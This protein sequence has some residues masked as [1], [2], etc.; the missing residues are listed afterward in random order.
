MVSVPLSTLTQFSGFGLGFGEPSF[1]LVQGFDDYFRCYPIAM[2]SDLTRKDDANYGGKIFLPQSALHKLTML[3]IR[4]PMLFHISSEGSGKSTHSGVLEFTAEEGRCYLP[5]WMLDTI[6]VEPGSLVN[7]KTADLPQGSFVKLEP[8]SVDFLDI[9]DPKAVLENALRKFTTLTV[10]DIIEVNYNDQIYKIKILE[11]KPESS[12]RGICVIETDLETDF[13]P[14]V[15]YVEPD[16]KA[17]QEEQAKQK[18]TK[19]LSQPSLKGTGSMAQ[20]IN[21]G[22]MIRQANRGQQ[23]FQ[24]DGVKLSG[25]KVAHEQEPAINTADIDLSGPIR[26]LELPD[27]YLFFGFPVKV[28]KDEFEEKR[29]QENK[30]HFEGQGQSLRNSKKRKDK[31][32]TFPAVKDKARS[33][34]TIVIDSD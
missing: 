29:P 6:Q 23:K 1:P 30:P 12:S 5:Q 2:M 16:Y 9:S 32:K 11:A 19:A 15:G 8:Q 24:G 13:A 18:K 3:N 7:I 31:N 33:P 4:Y 34:E 25:K 10:D 14:P 21:Y 20:Q 27:G 26:K 28:Y 17:L 22:E